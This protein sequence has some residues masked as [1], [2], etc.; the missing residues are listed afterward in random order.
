MTGV[1]AIGWK[2][3]EMWSGVLIT[4]GRDL[5]VSSRRF[6]APRAGPVPQSLLEMKIIDPQN[7]YDELIGRS[8]AQAMLG[9]CSS[10]LGWDE[11]TYMPAGGAMHR[12]AQMALLAG[13]HHEWATDPMLDELLTIVEG[14]NLVAEP[15]RVPTVNVRALRRIHD[16]KRLLPRALV[17]ELARTSSLAQP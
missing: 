5:I 3:V 8:R 9:S 13:L 16:R 17:E 1:P 11:Q 6:D 14:S 2:R 12:G 10:V 15:D 7:A 4:R